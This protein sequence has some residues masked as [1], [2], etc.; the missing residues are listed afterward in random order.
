ME[1]VLDVSKFYDVIKRSNSADCTLRPDNLPII[2][3]ILSWCLKTQ[4]K[5]LM[6]ASIPSLRCARTMRTVLR[7]SICLRCLKHQRG[8]ATATAP[9]ELLD[10]AEDLETTSLQPSTSVD[11]AV[12]T[13]D[14]LKASRDRKNQL[15]PSRYVADYLL[16]APYAYTI[17]TGFSTDPLDMTVALYIPIG[18]RLLPLSIPDSTSLVPFRS[19]NSS[20][21]ITQSWPLTI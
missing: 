12:N 11:P 14:P 15:P 8:I 7:P 18:L 17:A 9:A 6:A 3:L 4:Q 21:H 2:E 1:V 10:L 19:P 13:F 16:V 20:P 5:W